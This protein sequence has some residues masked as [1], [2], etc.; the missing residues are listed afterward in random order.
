MLTQVTIAVPIPAAASLACATPR[1][2]SEPQSQPEPAVERRPSPAANEQQHSELSDLTTDAQ[3]DGSAVSTAESFQISASG[4]AEAD[5]ELPAGVYRCSVDLQGNVQG[6]RPVPVRIHFV[7]REPMNPALVDTT[8]SVWSTNFDLP[9]PGGAQTATSR[10][11]VRLQVAPASDWTLRCD[12]RAEFARSHRGSRSTIQPNLTLNDEPRGNLASSS[13]RD[14]GIAMISAIPDVY[15]CQVSVSGS[16]ADDGG[17]TQFKVE[18]REL[19]L[20][21]VSAATWSGEVEYALT[22]EHR[23]GVT[24][25]LSIAAGESAS[26]DILCRPKLS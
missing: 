2:R 24:P 13:A 10:V 16:F 12:T 5:H 11:E 3:R 23:I 21:D 19:T 15:T 26:W 4:D 9:L 6:D 25:T 14:S 22:G 7:S 8:Y 18:L 17:E 20:V 1:E